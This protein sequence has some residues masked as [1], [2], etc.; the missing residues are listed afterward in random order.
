MH[1]TLS[2]STARLHIMTD[3]FQDF[4]GKGVRQAIREQN[5]TT[6]TAGM[7][8]GYAQA[9]VVIT[10]RSLAFDF[11]LFCQRNPKPCPLLDVT[12]PGIPE[13]TKA[14]P[15][16]NLCFDVPRYRVYRNGE[17]V[18]EPTQ[19]DHLWNEDLVGFLLGCSFT[20][21]SA[22]LRANLPVRHLEQGCNVP[23]YQTNIACTPAGS[24]QGPMVVSMRP[25]KPAQAIQAVQVTSRYPSVHGA[26]IHWGDPEAIGI[27]DLMKPDFGDAVPVHPD[28]IPVFWACGVTPQAMVMQTKPDFVITHSPGCMFVTD[29]T[30]E[31]LAVG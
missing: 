27:S 18:E 2:L 3:H 14:A 6:P 12:E 15:G 4:T 30:D 5:I 31:S 19:I 23:M 22:M 26:P 20:F 21:E 17:L 25:L 13:P 1:P 16:A 24:L 11:L 29:I 9:N 28:E 8:H 7:A 10:P